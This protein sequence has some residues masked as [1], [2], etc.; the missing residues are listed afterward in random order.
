MVADRRTAEG[1]RGV[2]TLTAL[3]IYLELGAGWQRFRKAPALG[4][5]LG[6]IPTMNQS[7]EAIGSPASLRRHA[8]SQTPSTS[9]ARNRALG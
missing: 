7:G 9:A 1:V 3:T 8:R 4:A 6:L 5:W 2:D